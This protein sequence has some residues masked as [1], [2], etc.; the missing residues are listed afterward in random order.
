MLNTLEIDVMQANELQEASQITAKY[1][2]PAIVVHQDLSSEA[3]ILRAQLKSKYKII[4]P[5]DWPKGSNYGLL[6]LRGLS[7]DALEVEGFEILLTE[8]KSTSDTKNEAKAVTDFIRHHLSELHEIRLVLGTLSR[9]DEN[10]ARI[11]EAIKLVRAPAMIRN[12]ILLKT[13]INKAS[14][15]IHNNTIDMINSIVKA[16]IK[17]SGNINNFRTVTQC[18]KAKRYAVNLMQAKTII[19]EYKSQPSEELR[20]LLYEE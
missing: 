3:Y 5:I 17:I 6:K 4:T 18:R 19:K 1:N 12:D 2:L 7:T 10:I 20:K 13:Q 9:D 8:G 16:P 15:E 14:P 11:C